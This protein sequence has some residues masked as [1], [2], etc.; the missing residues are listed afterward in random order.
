ML[1]AEVRVNVVIWPQQPQGWKWWAKG[2]SYFDE[3]KPSK[4]LLL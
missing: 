1:F 3:L 4:V 2:K